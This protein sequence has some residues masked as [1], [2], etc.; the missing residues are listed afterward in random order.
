[1]DG[2]G[3]TA[4]ETDGSADL[5]APSG[6]HATSAPVQASI[7]APE[8]H[9]TLDMQAPYTLPRRCHAGHPTADTVPTIAAPTH[10]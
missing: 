10:P 9:L 5:M 2:D 4:E 7:A 8:A 3:G 6:P 1:V